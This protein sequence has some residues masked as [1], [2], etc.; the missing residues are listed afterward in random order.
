MIQ[1][2][3]SL[4]LSPARVPTFARASSERLIGMPD[5]EHVTER[6]PFS[7]RVV[8]DA[9]ALDKA[10]GIRHAAYAR[11]VPDFADKLRAPEPA[12]FEDGVAVLLAESRLD[13]SALGTMR[14][15]SNRYRPL[16]VEQSV[17]LP[18]AMAEAS[19][20]EV[21][22]LGVTGERIGTL[23]KT[24][25][26]KASFQYCQL[27][28]IDWAIIAARSPL[29]RQYERL[30]FKDVFPDRGYIAMRHA[31]DLPH[32][33]L[34]FDIQSG[35]RHWSEARHPLLAFFCHTYHPDID[36]AGMQDA[37]RA[38]PPSVAGQ[39]VSMACRH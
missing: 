19:L 9:A 10:V 14:I 27:N 36:L 32:R 13:G 28:G 25:L 21:T 6:L 4:A 37:R 8:R 2:P 18:A 16:S 11:H 35:E 1:P 23:V 12:D 5:P 39:A 15:Q 30:L 7:V 26:I 24:V 22:R 29:D 3:A 34:A 38:A 17:E 33:V 20:A 31:N